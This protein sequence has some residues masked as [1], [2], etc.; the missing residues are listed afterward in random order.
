M[1]F[2]PQLLILLKYSVFLLIVLFLVMAPFFS[3]HANAIKCTPGADNSAEGGLCNPVAAGSLQDLIILIMKY[4]GYFAGSMT[5]IAMVVSGFMMVMA[6]GNSEKIDRA[7]SAFQWALSGFVIVL[8]AFVLVSAVKTFMGV[9]DVPTTAYDESISYVPVNPFGPDANFG[10][11]IDKMILSFT[12]VVGL[13]AVLMLIING[14]KYMTAAGN[15]EQATAA[16]TGIQWSVVGIMLIVL[17]YVIV[18]A[19]ATFF[20]AK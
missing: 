3:S 15:D 19:L 17:A 1:R 6:Q 18:R 12:G 16:K 10:T 20:G 7:K 11:L 2:K 4:F 13:I 8:F 5:V 14:V 9:Q